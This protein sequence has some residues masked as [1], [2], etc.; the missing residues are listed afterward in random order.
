VNGF[1]NSLKHCL[2]MLECLAE[3]TKK[4]YLETSQEVEAISQELKSIETRD[5]EAIEA[6]S[7]SSEALVFVKGQIKKAQEMIT[8]ANL[9]SKAE[10]E[11]QAEIIRLKKIKAKRLQIQQ[12]EAEK[13]MALENLKSHLETTIVELNR[14]TLKAQVLMKSE[15]ER[16]T[17]M[18]AL[19]AKIKSYERHP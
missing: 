10:P 2:P 13:R 11:C 3:Q 16:K 7:V 15:E 19:E 9:L 14:D 5:A 12:L 4:N 8:K 1:Y 17:K 6:M 18:P